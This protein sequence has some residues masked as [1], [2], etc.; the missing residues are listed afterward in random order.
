MTNLYNA[1]NFALVETCELRDGIDD[2]NMTLEFWKLRNQ[3]LTVKFILMD[4][5]STVLF[6]LV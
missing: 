6:V 4:M 2:P 5:C 3:P 1:F